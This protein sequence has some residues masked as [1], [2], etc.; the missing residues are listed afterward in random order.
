MLCLCPTYDLKKVLKN[1]KTPQHILHIKLVKVMYLLF[2][3]SDIRF[4]LHLYMKKYHQQTIRLFRIMSIPIM[5]R[6]FRVLRHFWHQIK[7]KANQTPQHIHI[8]IKNIAST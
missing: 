4:Q 3:H 8:V 5:F 7:I 1:N 6:L 2:Q